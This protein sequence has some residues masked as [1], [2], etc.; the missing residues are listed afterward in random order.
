VKNDEKVK[1]QKLKLNQ[2]NKNYLIIDYEELMNG[3]GYFSYTNASW[4]FDSL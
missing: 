4:N 1:K 3:K 2:K